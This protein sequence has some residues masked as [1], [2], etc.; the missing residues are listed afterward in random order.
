MASGPRG[1]CGRANSELSPATHRSLR[2]ADE[3]LCSGWC[4]ATSR[5]RTES[6]GG[7]TITLLLSNN[8]PYSNVSVTATPSGGR[9]HRGHSERL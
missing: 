9:E 8:G 2:P 3:W 6:Y 4:R 7:V 5:W 1:P